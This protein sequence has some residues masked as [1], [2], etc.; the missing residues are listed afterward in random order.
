MKR[1]ITCRYPIGTVDCCTGNNDVSCTQEDVEDR[2]E[3][4]N[5]HIPK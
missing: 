5:F 3:P 2:H 4:V 1:R